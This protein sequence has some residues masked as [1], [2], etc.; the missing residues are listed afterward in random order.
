MAKA[1][2]KITAITHEAETRS[3]FLTFLVPTTFTD[4]ETNGIK[5]AVASLVTKHQGQVTRTDD[6]GKRKMAYKIKHAGKWHTDAHYVHLLFTMPSVQVPALEKDV[7]LNQNLM[8]HLI[9]LADE[10]ATQSQAASAESN[11]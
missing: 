1:A 5:E 2:K 3:Y 7:Y 8:R 4:S 11:S 6:W 10:T 9:V